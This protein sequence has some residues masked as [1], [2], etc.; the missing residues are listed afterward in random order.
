MNMLLVISRFLAI[1]T[2]LSLSS[3]FIVPRGLANGS[4]RASYDANGTQIIEPLTVELMLQDMNEVLSAGLVNQTE[5]LQ[6]SILSGS[7]PPWTQQRE[8]EKKR[9]AHCACHQ[10]MDH[11]DC[12]NA[13]Q[14]MR[15]LINEQPSRE[16]YVPIGKGYFQTFETVI[17]HICTPPR[18]E[19]VTPV[20]VGTFDVALG[21][22]TEHCGSYTPG[23]YIHGVTT[24][25][26]GH[27]MNGAAAYIGYNNEETWDERKICQ[28]MDEP[29]ADH[30]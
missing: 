22:L 13:A 26:K 5:P 30:C 7:T 29:K 21:F 16:A 27:G 12:D 1:L 14:M 28:H 19:G 24:G 18:N 10:N 15:D 8:N 17:T 23:V 3:A 4:Y 2:L 20:N 11:S 25:R 9:R 6:P